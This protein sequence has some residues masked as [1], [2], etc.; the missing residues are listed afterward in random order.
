MQALYLWYY[1]VLVG[2]YDGSML[3][4]HN[5]NQT[6]TIAN[7]RSRCVALVRHRVHAGSTPLTSKQRQTLPWRSVSL[8]PLSLSCQWETIICK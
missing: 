2:L 7:Q 1:P 3:L 5:Q 8:V 4:K 6:H